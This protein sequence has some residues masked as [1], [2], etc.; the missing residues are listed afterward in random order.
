MRVT[1]SEKSSAY[2][3]VV[4]EYFEIDLEDNVLIKGNYERK[5][6]F[7]GVELLEK[8]QVVENKNLYHVAYVAKLKSPFSVHI[9]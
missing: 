6:Y 8:K 7:H 9:E 1:F 2:A 3:L 5:A 4:E